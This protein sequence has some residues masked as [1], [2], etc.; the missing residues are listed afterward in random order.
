MSNK[1]FSHLELVEAWEIINDY[2]VEPGLE[3][4]IS[5][6]DGVS[7]FLELMK[8]NKK[9]TKA[10]ENFE[11]LI[12]RIPRIQRFGEIWP[13][14]NMAQLTKNS[15]DLSSINLGTKSNDCLRLYDTTEKAVKWF[16]EVSEAADHSLRYSIDQET[17]EKFFIA[18]FFW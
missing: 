13:V 3:I 9:L 11:E 6:R 10:S 14:F 17:G 15:L 5:C 18:R 1:K 7:S 8:A 2:F 4:S 12:E 16:A